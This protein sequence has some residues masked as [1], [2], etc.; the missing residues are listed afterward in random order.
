MVVVWSQGFVESFNVVGRKAEFD[1]F[2]WEGFVERISLEK[3]DALPHCG[4]TSNEM[5]GIR[6]G[7][8]MVTL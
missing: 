6:D 1:V 3:Q 2:S 5:L 8:S 7:V 4:A